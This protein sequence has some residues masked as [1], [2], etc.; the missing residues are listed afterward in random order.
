L[1]SEFARKNAFFWIVEKAF[2]VCL[3]Q[4]VGNRDDGP[5]ISS[6][7]RKQ[8]VLH[9]ESAFFVRDDLLGNEIVFRVEE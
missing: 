2:A 4:Q 1:P 8:N 9:D 6:L 5:T 7:A 3:A